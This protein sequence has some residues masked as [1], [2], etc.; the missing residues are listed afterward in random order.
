MLGLLLYCDYSGVQWKSFKFVF[1]RY[2]LEKNP[3]TLFLRCD[4][5]NPALFG[6]LVLF[7]KWF[8]ENV[9]EYQVYQQFFSMLR[10]M[11]YWGY[12]NLGV[13][14]FASISVRKIK[15]VE[16]KRV[17]PCFLADETESYYFQA[18]VVSALVR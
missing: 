18:M 11:V 16:G 6:L 15:G 3:A 7:T 4:G 9:Q 17:W 5:M 8:E 14:I 10:R 12:Q 13:F 2:D 1:T